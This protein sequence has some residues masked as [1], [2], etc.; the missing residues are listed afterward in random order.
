MLGRMPINKFNNNEP[1]IVG[2]ELNIG[3]GS[4]AE[5]STHRGVRA[6]SASLHA[7]AGGASVLASRGPIKPK[8]RARE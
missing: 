7:D 1:E 3:N 4:A 2:L 8:Q 5:F 6:P